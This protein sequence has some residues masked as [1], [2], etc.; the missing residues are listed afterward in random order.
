MDEIMQFRARV[1]EL[2]E[3]NTRLLEELRATDRKRMVR[4]FFAV[5]GQKIGE[6]PHVP[7]E[8]TVR[9]RA[10][11]V[12]EEVI[13]EMVPAIFDESRSQPWRLKRLVE[14]AMWVVENCP[15]KVNLPELIDA[16]IDTD[17]VVE[18]LRIAFGVDST[19]VW[20]EVQRANLSKLGGPRREDGKLLKPEG[21]QAPDIE[22]SLRKQGWMK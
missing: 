4:E 20:Q 3:S 9:F 2:L 6:R 7:D 21:W 12:I 14:D 19:P 15:V 16:T 11:L 13:A 5:A 1:Q 17:Y 8:E 10:R 18:G 22:G